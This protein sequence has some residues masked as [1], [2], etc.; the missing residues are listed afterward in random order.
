[1]EKQCKS[2][3]WFVAGSCRLPIYVD[4]IYYGGREVSEEDSCGLYEA[5]ER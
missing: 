3:R 2:C 4:G 1:M 5:E